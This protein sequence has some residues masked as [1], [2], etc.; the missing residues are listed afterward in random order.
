MAPPTLDADADNRQLIRE[1]THTFVTLEANPLTA[2]LAAP[3]AILQDDL[4]ASLS[5]ET[6]LEIAI[7]RAE[8]KA[9]I[10]DEQI[11][12]LVDGVKHACLALTG[13][14]T[15]KEPYLTFFAKK[16]PAEIKEPILDEE[17][18][19]TS[20]WLPALKASAHKSLN[21]IGVKL[22]PL[23]TL[24]IP[25]MK[26]LREANQALLD[27]FQIGGRYTLV[28]RMNA[29][30]KLAHGQLGQ[31]VH[32]HPELGLVI[33]FP[34]V[35]FLHDTR[36]RKDTPASLN[37]QIEVLKKKIAALEIKRDK[38]AAILAAEKVAT[39]KKRSSARLDEI[40]RAEQAQA[41]AA[42]RLAA[43]RAEAEDDDQD[44]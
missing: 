34:E 42:A 33:T 20:A 12:A 32:D 30:R 36:R 39:R 6:K 8:A 14:D 43:L 38:L 27:F 21:D 26:D 2:A 7:A 10:L 17:V 25:A 1:N 23:L 13:G 18:S 44:E 40:A 11:D 19:D 29:A 24:A 15:S 35:F 5:E 31:I 37:T 4:L 28:Q 9:R 3:F 22:E 41:E 16:D